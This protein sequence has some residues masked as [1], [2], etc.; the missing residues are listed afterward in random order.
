MS[1]TA[2]ESEIPCT[3]CTVV[4]QHGVKGSCVRAQMN[5]ELAIEA[6]IDRY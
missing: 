6:G 1:M 3:L 2:C 4:A 5:I